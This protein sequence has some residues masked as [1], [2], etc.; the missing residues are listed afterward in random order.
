M[1]YG[2]QYSP[3]PTRCS[4]GPAPGLVILSRVTMELVPGVGTFGIFNCR[5]SRTGSSLSRHANGTAWDAACEGQLNIDLADFFV[6]A[7]QDLGVQRVI[8][9]GKRHD[10]TTG[11]REWDSR[12]GERVWERY[13]GPSHADHNHVEL[14]ADAAMNLTEE[15]VRAA[16][17]K[18]WD[19]GG[20]EFD[21]ADLDDL[22]EVVREEIKNADILRI[23]V[24]RDGKDEKLAIDHFIKAL[25]IK[26]GVL[27]SDGKTWIGA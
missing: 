2:Y 24:V 6:R 14:C 21:M 3:A 4:S 27:S 15:E 12:D 23:N 19:K 22:R 17:K 8:A 7:A 11:P 16:F 13:S 9:Y 20:D 5:P 18:H 10:G 1:A 25:A 26:A